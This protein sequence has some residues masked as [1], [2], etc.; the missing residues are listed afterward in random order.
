LQQLNLFGATPGRIPPGEHTLVVGFD[1]V[2]SSFDVGI[3]SGDGAVG[4]VAIGHQPGTFAPAAKAPEP[5]RAVI[6]VRSHH[7]PRH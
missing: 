1:C 2:T 4:L 5:K 6:T 7:R 3:Y